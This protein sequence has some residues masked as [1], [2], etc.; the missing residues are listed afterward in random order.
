MLCGGYL[1]RTS[2]S[3]GLSIAGWETELQPEKVDGHCALGTCNLHPPSSSSTIDGFIPRTVNRAP[4]RDGRQSL[5]SMPALGRAAKLVPI[6]IDCCWPSRDDH[7]EDW[8]S[9]QRTLAAEF[10]RSM[11]VGYRSLILVV[12][13]TALG[14]R[15]AIDWRIL[16][17]HIQSVGFRL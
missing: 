4:C 1:K 17:D 2:S 12:A 11:N 8:L 13:I 7:I 9:R 5:L 10:R 14:S 16:I 3:C 15:T 6:A